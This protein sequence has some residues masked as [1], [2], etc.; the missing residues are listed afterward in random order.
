MMSELLDIATKY[1]TSKEAIQANY[2]T[3]AAAHLSG[4]DGSDDPA[5]AQHRHDKRTR[6]KTPRGGDD[7]HDRMPA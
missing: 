4:S 5:L 1:A 6:D 2:N 7:G 3:K